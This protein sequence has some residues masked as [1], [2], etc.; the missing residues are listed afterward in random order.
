MSDQTYLSVIEKALK[1]HR[2]GILDKEETVRYLFTQLLYPDQPID[3]PKILAML[4]SDL[5]I[6]F[7]DYLQSLK[8]VDHEKCR[9]L[10]KE[11]EQ[12]ISYEFRLTRC[13]YCTLRSLAVS[14]I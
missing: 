3:C 2:G 12:W 6:E 4:P 13:A 8:N 10:C 14:V 7:K 1:F 9:Q 11:F 5:L